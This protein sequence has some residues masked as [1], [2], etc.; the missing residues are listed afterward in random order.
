M[1]H[2]F[3]VGCASNVATGSGETLTFSPFGDT[4]A[5][6]ANDTSDLVTHKTS[7]NKMKVD[8]ADLPRQDSLQPGRV[9]A[10]FKVSPLSLME[11]SRCG[12][13]RY[14]TGVVLV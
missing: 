10:I 4:L 12:R 7:K 11:T 5:G 13:P 6:T 8:S 1:W 14:N 9:E 2:L 3:N